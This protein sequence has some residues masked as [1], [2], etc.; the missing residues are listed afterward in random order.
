MANPGSYLISYRTCAQ[1]RVQVGFSC[2]HCRI[3][4]RYPIDRFSSEKDADRD[5]VEAWNAGYIRC[6]R[7]RDV[8]MLM[9]FSWCSPLGGRPVEIA[10][11]TG[12]E[13]ASEFDLPDPDDGPGGHKDR[14][15]PFDDYAPDSFVDDETRHDAF[16]DTGGA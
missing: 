12:T 2:R 1:T 16:A 10:R 8:G 3:Y 7:C 11:W 5:L 13:P 6:G 4:R 14:P 15:K 9:T